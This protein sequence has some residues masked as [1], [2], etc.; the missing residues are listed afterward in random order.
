[1][2]GELL[3]V[4]ERLI[5]APVPGKFRPLRDDPGPEG[6]RLDREEVIGFVDGLGRST[7]VQSPFHGGLMG[8]LVSDGE[9]VRE[10]QPVAWLRVA[11]EVD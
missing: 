10:G 7:P 1:M 3:V 6:D 4:P 9:R 8:L 11:S 2:D 5:L